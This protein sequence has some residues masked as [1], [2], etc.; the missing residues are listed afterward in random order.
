M[1]AFGGDD[2]NGLK[3]LA[4][5]GA[6][7]LAILIVQALCASTGSECPPGSYECKESPCGCCV[8]NSDGI[9]DSTDFSILLYF[10]K[11]KPPFRNPCVDINGDKKVD[12]I[13]F[14][15][16]LYQWGKP[17]IPFMGSKEKALLRE[18]IFGYNLKDEKI[19]Q[20]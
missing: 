1:M 11:K 12:S 10:W 16:L 13:D 19:W 3:L 7:A 5:L 4:L 17:G 20:V 14:S 6:G 9:V 8:Q 2:D 18:S 15:I